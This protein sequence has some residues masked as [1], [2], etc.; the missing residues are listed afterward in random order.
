MLTDVHIMHHGIGTTRYTCAPIYFLCAKQNTRMGA[1]VCRAGPANN[2]GS[3]SSSTSAVCPL[4]LAGARS[5]A[6]AGGALCSTFSFFVS[7]ARGGLCVHTHTRTYRYS[8]QA[9]A[10]IYNTCDDGDGS[11]S[12]RIDDDAR[13][14]ADGASERGAHSLANTHTHTHAKPV[15]EGLILYISGAGS[16]E[17]RAA[18]TQITCFCV[19]CLCLR[20]CVCTSSV[21][22]AAIV[23]L[24]YMVPR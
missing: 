9:S 16:A 23:C 21:A 8:T 24:V 19:R 6:A 3:A 1:A 2:A 17:P 13:R 4:L 5:V 20:V 7:C 11:G 15:T 12:R 10:H 14:D 18:R 22:A